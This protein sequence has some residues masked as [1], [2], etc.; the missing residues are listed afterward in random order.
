MGIGGT[1]NQLIEDGQRVSDRPAPSPNYQWQN[2]LL[3][4]N[5]LGGTQLLDITKK[6][7]WGYQTERV[8]VR[9]GPNGPDHLVGFCCRKDELHVLGWLFNNLEQGIKSL[10]RDHVG[11]IEDEDLEAV[12][13]R[14]EDS[15]LTKFAGVINAVVA[16]GIDFD[17][18]ERAAAVSRKLN[19]ARAGSTGF[20]SGA[21][22]AV[23]TAGQDS[24]RGG[25]ATAPWTTEEIGV[26]DPVS[27]QRMA[28][29]I[30]DL[31][32]AN[33]FGESLWA[34]P[35]IKSV[36][37]TWSLPGSTDD[38]SGLSRAWEDP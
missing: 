4:S 10:G 3:N 12:P 35:A 13:G 20:I 37:H 29:R 24:C 21:L 22:L 19:A 30:G 16:G 25:L 34:I 6:F 17:D 32:L 31:R 9:A 26:V 27:G 1:C 14:S 28:Q 23:E 36:N 7:S 18:V 33:E 2:P 15:P 38:G 8:M 11:L 5:A